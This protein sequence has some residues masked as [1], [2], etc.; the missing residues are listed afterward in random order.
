MDM[1][2]YREVSHTADIALRVWAEDFFGLLR[3][4]AEGLYALMGVE[5][6]VTPGGGWVFS[7]PQGGEE[8]ILVDFLTE[9][10]FLVEEESLALSEFVFDGD[11]N[12][13]T[14][15]ATGRKIKA[16]EREIKAVTFHRLAVER[17]ASG[18]VTTITFDV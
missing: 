3:Y 4:A 14:V 8:T 9:L 10:L 11:Q 7:I 12:Q 18:L 17:S 15:R 13:V 1:N 16:C 6:E 2:G 5:L